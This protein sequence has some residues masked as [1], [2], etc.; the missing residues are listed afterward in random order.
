MTQAEKETIEIFCR[1]FTQAFYRISGNMIVIDPDLLARQ[2]EID[3]HPDQEQIPRGDHNDL[4]ANECSDGIENFSRLLPAPPDDH[5]LQV[6][7]HCRN[8]DKS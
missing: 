5:G 1:E 7:D 8:S 3:Q 6:K 2:I 4:D